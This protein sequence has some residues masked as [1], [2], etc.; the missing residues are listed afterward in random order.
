MNAVIYS[1]FAFVS[2]RFFLFSYIDKSLE[3][4]M[5]EVVWNSEPAYMPLFYLL[6][7]IRRN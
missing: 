5:N 1:I 2:E 6:L 7:N 3:N 4:Q